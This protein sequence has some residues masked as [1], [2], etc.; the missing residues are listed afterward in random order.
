MKTEYEKIFREVLTNNKCRITKARLETFRLLAVPE[1]QSMNEIITRAKGRVDRVS[2][3]RTI[4]LFERLGIITRIQYGWKYKI[5]LSDIFIGH[6]HH[7]S[8]LRC[9]N[10][11]GIEEEAH[12]DELIEQLSHKVGFT[13][14]RHV[15]EVEGYCQSCRNSG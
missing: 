15:F 11:I 1:P 6:H 14:T 13:P 5:E 9:S 8:C 3:Y 10:T 7:M 12:I 2:V 4:D